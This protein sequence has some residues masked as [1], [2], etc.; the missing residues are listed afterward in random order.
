MLHG[1]R[2]RVVV[3]L[4]LSCIWLCMAIERRRK[5]RKRRRCRE[6]M[7]EREEVEEWER[8]ETC[9]LYTWIAVMVAFELIFT[10]DKR[11]NRMDWQCKLEASCMHTEGQR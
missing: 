9:S 8:S 4:L 6:E 1:A 2:D 5:K 3:G 7:G 11:R 10:T